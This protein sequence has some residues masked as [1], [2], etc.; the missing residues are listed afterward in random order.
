MVAQKTN[1]YKIQ[2]TGEVVT[3]HCYGNKIS[4]SQQIE[5]VTQ[6]VKSRCCKPYSFNLIL[7]NLSNVGK[8]IFPG[9]NPK[10]QYL[11]LEKENCCLVST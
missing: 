1:L 10:G 2:E 7:F 6:K 5:N 9:L 8:I 3:S 11:S 4:G